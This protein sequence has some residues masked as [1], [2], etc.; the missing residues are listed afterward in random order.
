MTKKPTRTFK[1]RRLDSGARKPG[2][3]D[4][5]WSNQCGNQVVHFVDCT[6]SPNAPNFFY[7]HKK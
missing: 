3:S 1:I 4:I 5:D 6:K 7:N 2:G